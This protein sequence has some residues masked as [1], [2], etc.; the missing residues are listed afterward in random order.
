MATKI[1]ETLLLLLSIASMLS[2]QVEGIQSNQTCV[3]IPKDKRQI[4][5][6][7][8]RSLQLRCLY[9]AEML[10][11]DASYL[12][13]TLRPIFYDDVNLD[14][15]ADPEDAFDP[16]T[17]FLSNRAKYSGSKNKFYIYFPNFEILTT[18]FVRITLTKFLYVPSFAF[19]NRQPGSRQRRQI[20][21]VV[22]ELPN[23]FDFGIDEN[24][25]SSVDVTD[26]LLIEGPFN[27]INIHT[28]AFR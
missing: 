28:N 25:F 24:A 16:N 6:Q 3:P 1:I 15:T 18:P 22:F 4:V 23:A 5:C 10:R 13:A 14:R 19:V 7:C 21:S 17:D 11:M 20:E 27:H 2:P 12:D 8:S 26:T 9:N